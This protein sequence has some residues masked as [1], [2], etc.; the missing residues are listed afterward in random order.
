[1]ALVH[2]ALYHSEN[3]GHID[4]AHYLERL[5]GHLF[6]AHGVDPGRIRLEICVTDTTLDLDRALPCGLIVSELVS[7]ALKYAFPDGRGGRVAVELD[8][9]PGG[10]HALT[11]RDDGVGLPE[12]LDPG[13]TPTLGLQLVCRLTQQLGGSLQVER[14]GGTRFTIV[15][16]PEP[17]EGGLRA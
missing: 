8:V 16:T 14:T 7:N 4:L 6:R 9:E 12:G 5:C 10:A 15:F 3:L 1:M 17:H 2:E 13:R 11:V